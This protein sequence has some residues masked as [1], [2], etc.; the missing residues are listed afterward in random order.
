MKTNDCNFILQMYLYQHFPSLISILSRIK[1]LRE[2]QHMSMFLNK[3]KLKIQNKSEIKIIFNIC[4][5]EKKVDLV[6]HNEINNPVNIH[7]ILLFSCR[8]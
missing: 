1:I 5:K 6:K 4:V 2:S 7:V 8:W 3:T